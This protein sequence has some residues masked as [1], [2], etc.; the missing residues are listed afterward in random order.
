MNQSKMYNIDKK[1]CFRVSLIYFASVLFANFM[2]QLIPVCGSVSV[3][4][5]GMVWHSRLLTLWGSG[6]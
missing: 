2:A 6:W 1:Y 3:S 5:S 4:V